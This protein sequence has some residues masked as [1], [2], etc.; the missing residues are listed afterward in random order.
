MITIL[1]KAFVYL[2]AGFLLVYLTKDPI[3]SL[4]IVLVAIIAVSI[5]KHVA[6]R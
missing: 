6:K 3:I 2:F 5:L 1:T 4:S